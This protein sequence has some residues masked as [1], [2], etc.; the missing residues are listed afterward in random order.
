M[1]H[2]RIPKEV[3]YGEFAEGK[4]SQ[5]GQKKGYKDARKASLKDFNIQIESWEHLHRVE[6]SDVA[7]AIKKQHIKKQNESVKLK[8]SE[9]N[10][11]PEPMDHHQSVYS[12]IL[13][14]LPATHS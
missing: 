4:R 3:F 11:K 10:A 1:P 2:E 13:L 8:E 9:K 12:Q 5:G 14:G 6:Q 7:S